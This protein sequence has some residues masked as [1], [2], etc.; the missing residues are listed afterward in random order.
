[1]KSDQASLIQ[2]EK[3]CHYHANLLNVKLILYQKKKRI[4]QKLIG[5]SKIIS[6]L[7]LQNKTV[8]NQCISE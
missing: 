5:L 1:M 8:V 7:K 4:Y 2:Q 3:N 6:K